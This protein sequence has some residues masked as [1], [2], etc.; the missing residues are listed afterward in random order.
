V[1]ENFD[2]AGNLLFS[3]SHTY[4]PFLPQEIPLQTRR[5]GRK[6]KL[7]ATMAIKHQIRTLMT[8]YEDKKTE[9][10]EAGAEGFPGHP[11]PAA[12]SA[13]SATEINANAAP[14]A[15]VGQLPT[16]RDRA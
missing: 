13:V 16:H 8:Q 1:V 5:F 7:P 3:F 11:S 2:D 14:V 6:M 9:A 10:A 4:K 12:P 15:F